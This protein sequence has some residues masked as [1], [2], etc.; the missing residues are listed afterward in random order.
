LG[1]S[2]IVRTDARIRALAAPALHAGEEIVGWTRAWVSIDGRFNVVLAARTRDFVVCT[3]ERLLLWSSGFFTR[4]PRRQVFDEAREHLEV[5]D[6]GD[7]PGRRLRVTARQ[8]KPLRFEFG[9]D[10][11]SR[12]VVDA[13]LGTGSE[14]D[15]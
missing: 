7:E 1:H 11:R 2:S 5:T 3:S 9:D 12:A 4:R 15:T 13:L 6:I 8:R 14:G 10:D